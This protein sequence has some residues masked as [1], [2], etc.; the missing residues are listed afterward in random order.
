MKGQDDWGSG[1]NPNFRK[2]SPDRFLGSKQVF[3]FEISIR[4]IFI[5]NKVS[6][7]SMDHRVFQFPPDGNALKDNNASTLQ[8]KTKYVVVFKTI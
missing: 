3:Q 1:Q 7:L 4:H 5:M 6:S 2:K 8:F